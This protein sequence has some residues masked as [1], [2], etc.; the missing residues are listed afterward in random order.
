MTAVDI[1]EIIFILVVF[2]VGI[3]GFIKVVT[4]DDKN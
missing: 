3:M 4:S 1:F 2:S